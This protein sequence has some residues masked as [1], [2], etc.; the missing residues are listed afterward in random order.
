MEIDKYAIPK[1]K[2]VLNFSVRPM[3]FD[4]ELSGIYEYIRDAKFFQLHKYNILLPTEDP[5]FLEYY[6][7]G[8]SL[9]PEEELKLKAAFQ[10]IYPNN[11][12]D[13]T[14]YSQAIEEV[15]EKEEMKESVNILKQLNEK[16]DFKLLDEYP[17]LL[18][19]YGSMGT[20]KN[21]LIIYNDDQHN[22]EEGF[23]RV[24]LHEAMH[25]GIEKNIVQR[26]GLI[27]PEKERVVDLMCKNIY[28]KILLNHHMWPG[29]EIKLDEYIKNIDDIIN[30]PEIIGQYVSKNPRTVS[31]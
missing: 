2:S 7:R 25:I 6:Q 22:S 28:A 3:T 4:E 11:S 16:W 8:E 31:R 19:R 24:I 14:K 26:F 15:F 20:L 18:T 29:A 12:H 10:N 23:V 1:E 17:I 21:N 5:S 30:L 13:V 27:Y 9:R